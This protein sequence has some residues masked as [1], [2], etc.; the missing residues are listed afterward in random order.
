[1]TT[2]TPSTKE[3]EVFLK[4]SNVKM[5]NTRNVCNKLTLLEEFNTLSS[6]SSSSANSMFVAIVVDGFEDHKWV[7]L[8]YGVD[9]YRDGVSRL[10][11]W[12]IQIWNVMIGIHKFLV[13]QVPRG[14]GRKATTV[15]LIQAMLER[16][17]LR[18]HE[19]NKDTWYSGKVAEIEPRQ[20]ERV[21]LPEEEMQLEWWQGFNR[22]C[23][24]RDPIEDDQ[25]IWQVV[26]A[27]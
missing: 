17:L 14:V 5:C 15:C 2:D 18:I 3:I 16:E 4:H 6:L 26:L 19:E 22:L 20:Y 8:R 24:R 10:G 27:P 21:P 25:S 9:Q 23:P 1:M 13:F 11:G 7:V 12:L